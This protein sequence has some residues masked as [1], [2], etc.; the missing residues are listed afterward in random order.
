MFMQ[1]HGITLMF[2]GLA[3]VFYLLGLA[4]AGGVFLAL[5]AA[6]EIM[7]WIHLFRRRH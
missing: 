6:A 3:L 2:L 4:T 1:R 5:G 7:F